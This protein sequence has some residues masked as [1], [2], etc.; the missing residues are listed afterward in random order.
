MEQ[1]LQAEENFIENIIRMFREM[2]ED[3][4]ATGAGVGEQDAI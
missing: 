4:A 2:R 1:K 3:I